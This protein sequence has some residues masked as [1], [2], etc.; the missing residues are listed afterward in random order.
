MNTDRNGD[1]L[2]TRRTALGAALLGGALTVTSGLVPGG[3]GRAE[4]ATAGLFDPPPVL[5]IELTDEGFAFPAPNPRPAGL[6]TIRAT[7]PVPAGHFMGLG[8][9]RNGISLE[10]G[11][12]LFWM[13]QSPD[14]EVA[15]PALRALYRDVEFFG[16]TGV[17]P[18]TDPIAATVHLPADT[19]YGIDGPIVETLNVSDEYRPA[20]PPRVHGAVRMVEHG[21]R[22]RF[23]APRKMRAKGS[24]LVVNHTSQPQE[25]VFVGVAPGTTDRDIQDYYDAPEGEKPPYPLQTQVGGLMAMSTGHMAVLHYDFPPGLYAILSFYRNPDTAVKR[26]EEGM[27]QVV[28]LV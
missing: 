26:A 3:S 24:Y 13:S 16:G 1:H 23:R 18:G 6:V 21:D 8:A 4:A 17:F 28:E 15:I 5:D 11:M 27:H 10:E 25:C 14:P 19:Y 20:M 12:R 22:T 9:A 7:T 2:L